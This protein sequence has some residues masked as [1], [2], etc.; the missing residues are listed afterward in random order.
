MVVFGYFSICS[1][2]CLVID[3][4][5]ASLLTTQPEKTNL[6]AAV[7]SYY[8]DMLLSDIYNYTLNFSKQC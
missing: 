8:A 1:A 2:V 5:L 4:P 7:V 3:T 6:E